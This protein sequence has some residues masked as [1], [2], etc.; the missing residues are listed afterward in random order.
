MLF[1]HCLT[2]QFA[3]TCALLYISTREKLR[4]VKH[5]RVLYSK[6][7]DI[8]RGYQSINDFNNLYK[9]SHQIYFYVLF[10]LRCKN[11]ALAAFFFLQN[12]L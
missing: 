5:F 6:I 1:R 12:L 4:T 9:R 8:C 3:L 11:L 7:L 2:I 10:I